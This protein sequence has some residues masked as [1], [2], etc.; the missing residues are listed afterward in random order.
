MYFLF[1]IS[2]KVGVD[3]KMVCVIMRSTS[4]AMQTIHESPENEFYSI[5]MSERRRQHNCGATSNNRSFISIIANAA[6][7]G[8]KT[9]IND[10]NEDVDGERARE[11]DGERK[12]IKILLKLNGMNFRKRYC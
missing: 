6:R 12:S 8:H 1:P 2:I 5:E 3:R 4:S 9:R 10:E 11:G 7:D